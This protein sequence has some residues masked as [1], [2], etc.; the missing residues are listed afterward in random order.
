MVQTDEQEH[1]L[2]KDGFTGIRQPG[3][4][5]LRAVGGHFTG[6]ALPKLAM[7]LDGAAPINLG[8]APNGFQFYGVIRT[9]GFETFRI[10]ETDGKVG[11]ARF[12]FG[13]DFTFGTSLSEIFLDGFESGDT[14][15]WSNP[16]P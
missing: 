4:I 3:E 13:D 6:S 16:T 10:E 15:A 8:S 11:Q 1:C 7:I 5:T 2:Y 14:S 12:V 9:L